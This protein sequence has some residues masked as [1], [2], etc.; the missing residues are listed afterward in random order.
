MA[1]QLELKKPD[2][3]GFIPIS[4]FYEGL[5]ILSSVHIL[6]P[7][8]FCSSSHDSILYLSFSCVSFI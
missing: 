4:L 7:Y 2:Y 1:G 5:L 6:S 3:N 8:S